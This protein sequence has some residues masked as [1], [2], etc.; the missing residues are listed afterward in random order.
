M[1]EPVHPK[2]SALGTVYVTLSAALDWE[3]AGDFTGIEEA[4][5]DLTEV[6]LVANAKPNGQYR[7]RLCGNQMDLQGR[8]TV[9]GPL[10]I[11]HNA[12]ARGGGQGVGRV[13]RIVGQEDKKKPP[14]SK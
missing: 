11:I 1:N 9:E 3:R 13:R 7:R 2:L 5:R 10:V 8:Y 12:Q 6:C 14:R 4:R